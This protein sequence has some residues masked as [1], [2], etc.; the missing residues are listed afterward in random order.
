MTEKLT[1]C[2]ACGDWQ[3]NPSLYS[4]EEQD[5]AELVHCGCEETKPYEP[6][7]QELVEAGIISLDSQGN[8]L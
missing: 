2:G 3:Q 6:T 8:P 5:N 7:T 4:K 1:R